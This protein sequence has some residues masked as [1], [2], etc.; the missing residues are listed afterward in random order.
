MGKKSDKMYMTATEWKED[1]GGMKKKAL[2]SSFK[3][4][5]FNCCSLS[6][7]P[8]KIPVCT[9]KGNVF[10][11]LN[12]LPWIKK[13]KTNP[14]T[15]ETLVPGDLVRLK[16]AKN[17]QGSYHCP[18]TFKTFTDNSHIVAI[19]N[20]GNVYDYATLEEL[21]IKSKNWKDLLTDEPFTRKDIITLQDPHNLATRDMNAFDF[22]K[23][24]MQGMIEQ[25]KEHASQEADP[26]A[27]INSKGTTSRILNEMAAASSK[28]DQDSSSLKTKSFVEKGKKAKNEEIFSNG[29]QA[30]S[31]TSM[32]FTPTLKASAAIISDQELLIKNVKEKGQVQIKTNLGDMHF[33]LYCPQ[34]PRTCFNMI[35]HAKNGYYNDV[36]FHR[37]IRKFMLQGL[38]FFT[39]FSNEKKVSN[40]I[41]TRNRRRPNWNR[42]GWQECF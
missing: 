4:L 1:F 27:N 23:K 3:K 33:E 37:S 28:A 32:A 2:H 20:T 14:L 38:F 31:F 12:I 8:F 24:G 21:N 41:A 22:V 6:F 17:E 34:A 13:H 18:I 26:A 9:G 16:F 40:R 42:L 11:L 7:T 19:K 15:G 29:L 10:D 30:Y 5:P 36:L 39:F 35:K 25:E